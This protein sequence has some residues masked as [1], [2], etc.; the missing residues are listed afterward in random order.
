MGL[1]TYERHDEHVFLQREH[2]RHGQSV[3]R[4]FL[5]IVQLFLGPHMDHLARVLF[6]KPVFESVIVLDVLFPRLK[7]VEA[8][9]E[10]FDGALLNRRETRRPF[11]VF[12][13]HFLIIFIIG[14]IPG[15]RVND[16]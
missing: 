11:S 6:G 3:S 4:H 15:V 16:Y 14:D 1:F 12:V 13:H 8:G 9:L 10:N 7:F 2:I 5:Q